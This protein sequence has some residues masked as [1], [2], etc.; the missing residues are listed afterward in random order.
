MTQ[1]FRADLNGKDY[2]NVTWA[3]TVGSI[4]PTT[5]L[6][7]APE[8][9]PADTIATITA[10]SNDDHSLV[11]SYQLNLLKNIDPIR[12]NCGD[13]WRPIKDVSGNTW[14]TDWGADSGTTYH[15]SPFIMTGSELDGQPLTAKSPMSS[16]YGSSHHSSY[17]PGNQFN[18]NFTL[19]NGSYGVT[20][21]F[22]NWGFK[23]HRALF[24]VSVNGQVV[25]SRYD[26]DSVGMNVA[27]SKTFTVNV[28]NKCLTLKFA[29]I[30]DKIAEVNGIQILPQ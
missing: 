10:T 1:Q 4:N 8:T 16:I 6:Y 5:G 15:G 23:P 7:T 14:S 12:I 2:S 21:L 18:Y 24:N 22:G 29:G 25:I 28:T 9:L 13:E 17:T 19:P 27:S 20:L 30:G 26:P 11:G 3:A